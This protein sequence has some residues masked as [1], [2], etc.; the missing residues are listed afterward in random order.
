MQ[1]TLPWTFQDLIG[2]IN[3][4]EFDDEIMT[5]HSRERKLSVPD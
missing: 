3:K 1:L 5:D 4:G 2:L